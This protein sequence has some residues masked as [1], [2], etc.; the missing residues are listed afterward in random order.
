MIDYEFLKEQ[1]GIE[2]D[3]VP[4]LLELLLTSIKNESFDEINE[5]C[6]EDVLI[7]L[8]NDLVHQGK[9]VRVAKFEMSAMEFSY[10]LPE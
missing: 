9:L 6:E 10:G 8:A 2:A 4:K 3:E 5:K 1:F 7:H